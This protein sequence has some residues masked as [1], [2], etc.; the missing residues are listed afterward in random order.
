[1]IYQELLNSYR[2]LV[3]LELGLVLSS[4]ILELYHISTRESFEMRN[5][6]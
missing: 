1:M 5:E 3:L 4:S 6:R 2:L